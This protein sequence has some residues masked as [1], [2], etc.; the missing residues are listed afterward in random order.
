ML[1]AYSAGLMYE[2]SRIV[3]TFL[4]CSV[5]HHFAEGENVLSSKDEYLPAGGGKAGGGEKV[6]LVPTL[7]SFNAWPLK[8]PVGLYVVFLAHTHITLLIL[9]LCVATK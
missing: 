9:Y 7:P 2:Y 1:N 8:L 6:V 3:V 5:P 4:P